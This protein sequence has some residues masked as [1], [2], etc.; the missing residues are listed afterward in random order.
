[1]SSSSMASPTKS[2][3]A[4]ASPKA[5]SLGGSPMSIDGVGHSPV[6]NADA[7]Q[8]QA[9]GLM[10]VG[11]VGRG[12]PESAGA[13]SPLSPPGSE[14]DKFSHFAPQPAVQQEARNL[15]EED[16]GAEE[17]EKEEEDVYEDEFEEFEEEEEEEAG[18]G[19]VDG[20]WFGGAD[21]ALEYAFSLLSSIP[22]QDLADLKPLCVARDFVNRERE[23]PGPGGEDGVIFRKALFDALNAD[24]HAM[25]DQVLI[26][27]R[28]SKFILCPSFLLSFILHSF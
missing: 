28:H 11:V 26:E 13:C 9:P 3:A 15:F 20:A 24:I 10:K 6:R 22:E 8:I 23:C 12:S 21:K 25:A 7:S 5:A 18:A 19:V 17:Q 16:A 1:M 27:T 14:A 2:T 4:G